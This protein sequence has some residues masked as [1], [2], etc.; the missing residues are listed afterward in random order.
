MPIDEKNGY[1][2]DP[3]DPEELGDNRISVQT[4][5]HSYNEDKKKYEMGYAI[6]ARDVIMLD[7]PNVL[8][9]PSTP[10]LTIAQDYVGAI[11]EIPTE[12][13]LIKIASNPL[14]TPEEAIRTGAYV[15]LKL[16]KG[17]RQSSL[18]KK[19]TCN[20]YDCDVVSEYWDIYDKK[21]GKLISSSFPRIVYLQYYN[22]G[23][24]NEYV[25][26]M[27]FQKWGL[28]SY[29]GIYGPY[30]NVP[31]SSPPVSLIDRSIYLNEYWSQ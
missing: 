10:L 13:V 2:Y 18:Y 14:L 20:G 21:S 5:Y 16:L 19:I 9:S 23:A 29:G 24:A 26:H 7:A 12:D 3:N 30:A 15:N 6:Q 17:P 4:K 28:S 22:R 27:H 25:G 31:G 8:P 11:N 1:Y